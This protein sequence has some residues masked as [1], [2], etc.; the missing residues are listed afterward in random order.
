MVEKDYL[1][2]LNLLYQVIEENK[3]VPAGRDNRLLEAEALATKFFFH[4]AST[5]YLS[6]GTNIKDFPSS[7]IGFFDPASIHVLTRAALETFLTFH[8]LFIAPKSSEE[9]DFRYWAWQLGGLCERQ[10]YRVSKS[11]NRKKQKDE[12]QLIDKLRKNLESNKIFKTLGKRQ[13]SKILKGKWRIESWRIIALD[14]GFDELHASLFYSYLCGYAHSGS[15]SILQIRQATT[16]ETQR[17]LFQASMEVIM[18]AMANMIFSY[19]KLFL[20]GKKVL[21]RNSRATKL[22]QI[23]VDIGRGRVN[24][25]D[26]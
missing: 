9:Q 12:K 16:K 10:K 6:R 3:G 5:L 22:A 26:I 1:R 19:C 24:C 20:N 2:V 14:A 17:N 18:I 15:L 8:Y 7:E 23:W 13:Q 11:E 21:E 25:L 4:S